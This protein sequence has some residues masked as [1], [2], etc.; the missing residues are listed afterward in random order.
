MMFLHLNAVMN[1]CNLAL[2][3]SCNVSWLNICVR[4]TQDFKDLRNLSK[5]NSPCLFILALNFIKTQS[6][7]NINFN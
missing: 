5:K 7:A 6:A 2:A 3:L 4:E 1:M